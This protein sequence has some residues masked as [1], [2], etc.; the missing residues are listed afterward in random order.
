MYLTDFLSVLFSSRRVGTTT[1]LV[2]AV[3]DHG[4]II[5]CSDEAESKR[6]TQ[7]GVKAVSLDQISLLKGTREI[8]WIDSSALHTLL[9]SLENVYRKKPETLRG[10]ILSEVYRLY[11]RDLYDL[12]KNIANEMKVPTIAVLSMVSDLE[13]KGFLRINRG[14][15]YPP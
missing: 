15:I 13:D 9:V 8:L 1:A 7:L 6:L 2:K 14:K 3:E 12:S 11:P 10:T 5:I 4:G